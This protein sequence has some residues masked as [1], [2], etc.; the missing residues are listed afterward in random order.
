M[1]RRWGNRRLVAGSLL[2][3]A[4]VVVAVF[5]PGL[6]PDSP[7]TQRLDEGLRPPTTDHPFGQD[8]LGRDVL[9]RVVYGARP[10]L[11]VG[12]L[13]VLGSAVIGLALG[14]AAGYR[15]GWVDDL[16]MRL[17]DVLLAFPGLLLTIALSAVLG[18]SIYHVVLALVAVSWTGYARLVRAE[19]LS[20]REREFVTAA[21]VLGG[22]PARIISRH[23]APQVLPLV[24]VQAAFGMA[25]AVAAE[26]GLSFLGLSVQPPVPSWGTMINEGRSFVLLAPH[27]AIFPGLALV[28]TVLA[29]N[30]LGDG[31][32]DALD[33]RCEL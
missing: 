2:V 8:K 23:L 11:A 21:R 1:N 19:I 33:I 16:F 13:A 26:A 32:R 12:L 15:G 7:T 5:A 24:V 28:T 22:A 10:S 3:L 18:P 30:L 6:A 29:L 17:V 31:L 4:L 25:G 9:T 14:A 20:L 27:L